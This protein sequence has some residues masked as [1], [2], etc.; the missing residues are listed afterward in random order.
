MLF[1]CHSASFFWGG[2]VVFRPLPYVPPRV[3]LHQEPF[4]ASESQQSARP[5]VASRSPSSYS[6]NSISVI[7]TSGIT[8]LK[9]ASIICKNKNKLVEGHVCVTRA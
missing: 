5:E 9:H 3:C 7:V 1:N 6:L 2:G 8:M 4:A